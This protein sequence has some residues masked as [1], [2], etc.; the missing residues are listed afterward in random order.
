[1]GISARSVTKETHCARA[2]TLGTGA[3]TLPAEYVRIS[4]NLKIT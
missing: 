3:G 2:L 4:E 1:M